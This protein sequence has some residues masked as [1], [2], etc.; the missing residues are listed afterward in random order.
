MRVYNALVC[1][2]KWMLILV[3]FYFKVSGSVADSSSYPPPVLNNSQSTLELDQSTLNFIS[4]V[5]IQMLIGLSNTEFDL[6]DRD[7]PAAV[8]DNLIFANM[9]E[10]ESNVKE[11]LPK[12][13]PSE[14]LAEVVT[15]AL[16]VTASLSRMALHPLARGAMTPLDISTFWGLRAGIKGTGPLISK[17]FYYAAGID[18]P[19]KSPGLN[20]AL[21]FGMCLPASALATLNPGFNT[22]T[23]IANLFCAQAASQ[24]QEARIDSLMS[25]NHTETDA[26][27]RCAAQNLMLGFLLL[28][29]SSKSVLGLA[30]LTFGSEITKSGCDCSLKM[31]KH[32]SLPEQGI[33]RTVAAFLFEGTFF[34]IHAVRIVKVNWVVFRVYKTKMRNGAMFHMGTRLSQ[35]A[36]SFFGAVL[37]TVFQLIYAVVAL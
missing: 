13:L 17:G 4:F 25:Q 3:V 8:V 34:L 26:L 23:I 9:F 32:K 33:Q 36:V 14:E 11:V 18:D 37:M 35:Y 28:S 29:L 1:P 15:P 30:S 2:Q 7:V 31:L 21:S 12:V 20:Y 10:M 16:F 24:F 19:K 22:P 27:T 5:G 6:R